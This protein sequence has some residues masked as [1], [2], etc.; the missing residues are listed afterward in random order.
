MRYAIISDIHSN[1]EAL[2]CVMN[3]IE[4]LHIDS[5]ICLG[6]IVGYGPFPDEC[7]I[8]IE[9]KCD[10]I[11]AGNHDFAAV[12]RINTLGFSTF[13]AQLIEWTQSQLTWPSMRLLLNLE[14]TKQV[15]DIFCVHGS[16]VLPDRFMYVL[17]KQDAAMALE[18]IKEQICVVGHSH[19]PFLYES[20]GQLLNDLFFELDDNKRYVINVGSVGQPRD[21]DPRSCF[22]VL[23]TNQNTFEFV[24]IEYDVKKTQAD[25]KERNL[26]SFLIERLAEGR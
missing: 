5:V 23:D 24:R 9:T 18:E 12:N 16:P 26:P 1:L 7:C 11:I 3:R 15:D 19:V 22:G 14:L 21:R 10:T 4:T 20:G 13:A 25:M 2:R 17:A 8:T 6:D